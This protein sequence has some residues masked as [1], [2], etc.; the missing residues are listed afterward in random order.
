MHPNQIITHLNDVNY[1]SGSK[2]TQ[3][4]LESGLFL[5]F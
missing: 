1:T 2:L 4:S 5:N 3:A